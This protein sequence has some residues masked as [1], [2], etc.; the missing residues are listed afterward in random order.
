MHDSLESVKLVYPYLI[1]AFRNDEQ[2]SART[3]AA[4]IVSDNFCPSSS[5]SSPRKWGTE[6]LGKAS[7]ILLIRSKVIQYSYNHKM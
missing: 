3:F 6:I 1:A 7:Y 4:E 5:K 2:P